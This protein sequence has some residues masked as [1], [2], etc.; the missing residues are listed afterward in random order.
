MF[1]TNFSWFNFRTLR[2]SFSI[3]FL[4]IL[5]KSSKEYWHKK[6]VCT[7]TGMTHLG[8]YQIYEMKGANIVNILINKW[9]SKKW[10]QQTK[11]NSKGSQYLAE[12]QWGLYSFYG[13]AQQIR[14]LESLKKIENPWWF[15]SR[16]S[17]SKTKPQNF[18]TLKINDYWYTVC[19]RWEWFLKKWSRGQLF[20]EEGLVK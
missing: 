17:V 10:Y 12:M 8:V 3:K 20:W 19:L 6:K 2:P 1:S 11:L 7:G 5:K 16:K 15:V 9:L 14:E 18:F 4:I 13:W